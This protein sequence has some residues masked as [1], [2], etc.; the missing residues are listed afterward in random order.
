MSVPRRGIRPELR[1][2]RG[3]ECTQR[4]GT[5]AESVGDETTLML[6]CCG[7]RFGKFLRL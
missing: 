5:R 2:E 4:R 3:S 7:N 1:A 6:T